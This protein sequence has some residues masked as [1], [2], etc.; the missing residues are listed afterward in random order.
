MGKEVLTQR[1]KLLT[2]EEMKFIMGLL[3]IGGILK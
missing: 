3:L 2:G 1:V